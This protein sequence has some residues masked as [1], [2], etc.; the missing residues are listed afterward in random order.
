V[1]IALSENPLDGRRLLIKDGGDFNGR[2]STSSTAPDSST[3]VD[4][5]NGSVPGTGT[6]KTARKILSAQKQPAGPTLFLGNLS[7]ET[8]EQSIRDMFGRNSRPAKAKKRKGDSGDSGSDDGMDDKATNPAKSAGIR[9][10][11]MGTFEDTGK[12]KGWT[13][14]DFISVEASTAA[15]TNPKNHHLDGRELVVEFASPE[16]VRRGG[17]R[18]PGDKVT[19]RTEHGKQSLGSVEG[20]SFKR[21]AA[22]TSHDE[23]PPAKSESPSKRRKVEGDS[24]Q[25]TLTH[26]PTR[27]PRFDRAHGKHGTTPKTR[28]KP[29]AA[30]ALAKRQD[31]AILPS[32]G[33]KIVF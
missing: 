11:R 19:H 9:K 26:D 23:D 27:T 14:V 10:I 28:P 25:E 6:T 22:L 29:G 24:E 31:P 20:S 17:I 21:K 18:K 32:Q 7:F 16:A 30:L 5:V 8:T 4:P 3:N 1:A 2:P 13:F 15:L 33:Q 12:C